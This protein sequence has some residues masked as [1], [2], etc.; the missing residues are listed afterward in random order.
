MGTWFSYANKSYLVDIAESL[1]KI[2]LGTNSTKPGVNS[3]APELTKSFIVE[4]H[5]L[6]IFFYT[7]VSRIDNCHVL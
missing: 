2:A 1:L 7:E 3:G 4:M 6:T 5:H